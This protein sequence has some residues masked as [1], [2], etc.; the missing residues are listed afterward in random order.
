MKRAFHF[1]SMDL[2]KFV[3]KISKTVRIDLKLVISTYAG[4]KRNNDRY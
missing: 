1:F 3:N 2:T 4:V